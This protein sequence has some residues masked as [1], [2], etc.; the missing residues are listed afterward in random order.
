MW[1]GSV[2][3]YAA[4]RLLAVIAPASLPRIE[5][6]TIDPLVLMF[7]L[8]ISL[9]AGVLFG[10]MPAIKY[11]GASVTGTLRAGGRSLS[12]SRE[13]HRARNALVVLQM[14]LAVVLL[15]GSGLMIRT[16]QALKQV[17]HP[18][19][20]PCQYGRA[21]PCHIAI[22]PSMPQTCELAERRPRRIKGMSDQCIDR[23]LSNSNPVMR[24]IRLGQHCL[25]VNRAGTG[26]DT[27]RELAGR[28]H[29]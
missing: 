22:P 3:R 12:Q 8:V 29:G 25:L 4:L 11:A 14:A 21:R 16:F 5:N 23:L 6:I 15:I 19:R 26:P 7:T 18:G 1:P 9:V 27:P 17:Q 20:A 10:I 13:A 2:C 28:L 24:P